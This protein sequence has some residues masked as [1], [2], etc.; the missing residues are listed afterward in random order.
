MSN[1]ISRSA[2]AAFAG[3]LIWLGGLGAPATAAAISDIDGCGIVSPTFEPMA[4]R[5]APLDAVRFVG[6]AKLRFLVAAPCPRAIPPF[7]A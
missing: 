1:V 3:L 2:G 7:D 6:G 4:L 5:R